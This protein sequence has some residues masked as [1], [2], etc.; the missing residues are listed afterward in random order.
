MDEAKAAAATKKSTTVTWPSV[1]D[2]AK[3]TA[4]Q[5]LE[6]AGVLKVDLTGV[7]SSKAARLAAIEAAR[8]VVA[9]AP[10]AKAETK[11]AAPKKEKAA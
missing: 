2:V 9:K 7:K 1:E 11:A 3:S 6:L 10:K 4:A 8:P 5:L